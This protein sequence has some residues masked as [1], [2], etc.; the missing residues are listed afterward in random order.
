MY[1]LYAPIKIVKIDTFITLIVNLS[2]FYLK[3]EIKC[4]RI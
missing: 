4:I 2:T 1:S 3:N